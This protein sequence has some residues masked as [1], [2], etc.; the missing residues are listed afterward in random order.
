MSDGEILRTFPNPPIERRLE[1]CLMFNDD[2][3]N[4]LN[5]MR[6]IVYPE[7]SKTWL[8]TGLHFSQ[9]CRMNISLYVKNVS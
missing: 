5:Q 3:T 4:R 8:H 1:L 9:L 7:H 2:T 6:T